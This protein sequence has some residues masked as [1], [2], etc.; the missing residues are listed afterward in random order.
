MKKPGFATPGISDNRSYVG[1][2]IDKDK[3][4]G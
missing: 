2:R 1:E 4:M 3:K